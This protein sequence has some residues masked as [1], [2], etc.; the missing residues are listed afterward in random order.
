MKHD[1]EMANNT[2]DNDMANNK[3]E[4]N[5]QPSTF[6]NLFLQKSAHYTR[7]HFGNG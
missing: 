3:R 6:A 1:Y 7:T 4:Y 5:M 2:C